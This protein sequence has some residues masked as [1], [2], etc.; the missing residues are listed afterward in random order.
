MLKVVSWCLFALCL[1]FACNVVYLPIAYLLSP[2]DPYRSEMLAGAFLLSVLGCVPASLLAVLVWAQR[3]RSSTRTLAI[4][5]VPAVLVLVSAAIQ[6]TLA[7]T[8]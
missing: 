8:S 1:L 5:S 4:W 7:V 2:Y 3:R 6:F